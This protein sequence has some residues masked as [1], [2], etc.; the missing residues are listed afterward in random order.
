MEITRRTD[1]A[2]RMLLA[3]AR[4]DAERP[5]SVRELAESSDVP[6]S[7]ARTVQR[8]LTRSG[9]VTTA[10]GP[11]GGLSLARPAAETSLLDVIRA[12][13]G[14]P[15]LSPCTREAGWCG[16]EETCPVHEVWQETDA[17]VLTILGNKTLAGLLA[18]D[19]R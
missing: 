3:L 11:A 13:Q 18:T 15:T 9:F 8:D 2:I 7:F 17:A 5:V 12:V 16:R 19:G 14:E 4:A 6:Y 1:Y 10:R